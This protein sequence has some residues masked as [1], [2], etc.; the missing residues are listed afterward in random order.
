LVG[1]RFTPAQMTTF[2]KMAAAG[3]KIYVLTGATEQQYRILFRERDNWVAATQ[4]IFV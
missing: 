4:G 2:H 1:S 3:V